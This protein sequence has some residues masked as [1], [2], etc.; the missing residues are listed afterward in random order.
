MATVE[1]QRMSYTI[2]VSRELALDYG[3][4]EPTPEER[5]QAA[6]DRRKW[7]AWQKRQNKR[8]ADGLAALIA[9]KDPLAQRLLNLHNRARGHDGRYMSCN[10]CSIGDDEVDWP[11]ITVLVIAEHHGIQMVEPG[12]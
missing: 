4:I 9:I 2:Q 7:Q 8:T 1:P 12:P 5:R 10:S 3:L 6:E 11:C